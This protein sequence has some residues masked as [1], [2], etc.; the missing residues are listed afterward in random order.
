MSYLTKEFIPGQPIT[1]PTSAFTKEVQSSLID[2]HFNGGSTYADTARILM[3]QNTESQTPSSPTPV[4]IPPAP[5]HDPEYQEYL[6]IKQLYPDLID[7][8][9]KSVVKGIQ[10]P[11][12]NVQTADSQPVT[13]SVP[14]NETAP[15]PWDDLFGMTNEKHSTDNNNVQ[16]RA[17][18]SKSSDSQANDFT[19][20]FVA[21]CVRKGVDYHDASKF[22]TS[23][24]P[25]DYVL[26]Y[27]AISTATPKPATPPPQPL[28]PSMPAEFQ[29][30]GPAP[31]API[32][33][34]DAPTTEQTNSENW[35]PQATRNTF[36]R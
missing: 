24:T 15:S 10:A 14:Q 18:D 4:A 20:K 32:N 16:E 29:P 1:V 12:A 7:T 13:P 21:E 6:K 2:H 34:V 19:Q 8:Y 26:L 28:T 5:Q 35:F 27:S 25:E 11:P 22:I 33:L 30:P 17:Q 9:A 3:G 36:W 31:V 23:L